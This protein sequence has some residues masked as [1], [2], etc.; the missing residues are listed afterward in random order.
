MLERNIELK[1]NPFL[2]FILRF[3]PIIFWG[4][5]V[6]VW[7]YQSFSSDVSKLISFFSFIVALCFGLKDLTNNKRVI[8]FSNDKITVLRKLGKSSEK[9][10]KTI[11]LDEIDDV[12]CDERFKS[13]KLISKKESQRGYELLEYNSAHMLGSKKFF[14]V[15]AELCRYL[16]SVAHEYI[17]DEVKAYIESGSI[18]E[19]VKNKTETGK[20]Q[21]SIL[22]VVELIFAAI[23]LGL[24]VI[25]L[26]WVTVT[27]A[28]HFLLG[29]VF[30]LDKLKI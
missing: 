2:V 13:I 30:I 25:A 29:V 23:P 10:I 4:G 20:Y 8:R 5:V 3:L 12:V 19:Y 17:N 9:V 11:L 7:A 24:S 15:K 14:M 1:R 6:S 21:A 18:S 28:Y 22:F 26:A 27:I 16:P